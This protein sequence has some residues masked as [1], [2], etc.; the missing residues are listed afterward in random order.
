MPTLEQDATGGELPPLE[1]YQDEER[2]RRKVN[3]QARVAE[4]E[5]LKLRQIADIVA[6][7]REPEW[8]IH[9]VIERDV[10]AVL[11][12]PRSTFK[13]FVALDWSMRMARAGHAGILLSGEGAGLDRRIAAWRMHHDEEMDLAALPLFALERAINL[14][15]AVELGHLAQA[16]E[17]L[18]RRPDFIVIDTLSKFSAGLDENDNGEVA[19]FLAALTAEIREEFSCTVL[20]VAHSGHGDAKRPRGASSLMCNPDVEYIVARPDPGGMVVTV[21]RERFK[22][23]PTMSPLAYEAK[24][25]DLGRLDRYGERVTSLALESTDAIPIS[26]KALGKAQQT[27]L[28][29]LESQPEGGVWTEPDLRKIGRDAGLHRNSARD[30]VLGLRQLGYFEMTIGGVRL[31]SVI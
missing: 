21:S 13:S 31:V 29:A 5:P 3:G 2:P 22:D 24:V 19:A 15:A 6:E 18:T 20:L 23:A 9:K 25:I 11:A 27:L 30:A 7:Q 10:L 1:A 8:L 14:N 4:S 28:A 12:G 17:E 16:M 26:R